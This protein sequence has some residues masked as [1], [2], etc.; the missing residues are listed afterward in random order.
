MQ[1][2]SSR[3]ARPLVAALLPA[4]LALAASG[5]PAEDARPDLAAVN[6]F[7]YQLQAVD[8]N[9]FDILNA[10]KVLVTKTALERVSQ[11]VKPSNGATSSHAAGH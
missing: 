3:T 9:A 7:A 11:R 8:V 1:S 4:V 6:D 5:A 2:D 10:Q